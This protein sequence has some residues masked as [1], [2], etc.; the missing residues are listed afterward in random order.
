MLLIKSWLKSGTPSTLSKSKA[1][2]SV[3]K[4]ASKSAGHQPI[5]VTKETFEKK[6]SADDVK[7]SKKKSKKNENEFPAGLDAESKKKLKTLRRLNPGKTDEELLAKMGK[8]SAVQSKSDKKK[9][10]FSF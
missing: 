6:E 4:A 10:W 7:N 2:K 8:K 9:N 5:K 1:T 3:K